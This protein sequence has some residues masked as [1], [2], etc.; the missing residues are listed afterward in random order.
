MARGYNQ[1]AIIEEI[2]RQQ[3]ES[4]NSPYDNVKRLTGNISKT[5]KNMTT[6][7]D[8]MQNN[9]NNPAIQKLGANISQAGTKLTNSANTVNNVISPQNYFKGFAPR[10]FAALNQS[11]AVTGGASGA[12]SGTIGATDAATQGAVGSLAGIP[13]AQ[14]AGGT[15]GSA[16]SSAIGSEVAGTGSA[17]G[18]SAIGNAIGAEIGGTAAGAGTGS[19]VGSAIGAEVGGTAAG[20]TAGGAAGGA[21]AG[22]GSAAAATGIGALVA[23][24][25]MAA[26]GNHRKQAKKSGEALL[27]AMNKEG[28]T[29][30]EQTNEFAK[31][32]Q[33]QDYTQP[34]LTGAAAPINPIQEYQNYL[35]DNGYGDDIINGVPQG[36]NYGNKEIDEWIK[37]YNAGAGASNPI[38]IPQTDEEIAAAKAGKFNAPIQ[39]ARAEET[40]KK[41]LLDKF[42]NGIG[43][44][45][46]G[47]Q[48]NRNNGF[49]PENL[50]RDKTKSK[51]NHI[52]EA[53]G[54]TARIAQNPLVQGLVAGGLSAALTGNPLYGLGQGYKFA[55]NRAMSNIYEKALKDYGVDVQN[56][57]LFGNY[58]SKDFN[59]L[60]APQ[61]KQIMADLAKAK[62]MEQENYHNQMIENQKMLNGIRQQNADTN[63]YKAKNGSKVTHISS[64]S[65]K[66]T[67]PKSTVTKTNSVQNEAKIQMQA[68]NGKVYLVPE[69][70]VSRYKKLGGK[71]VG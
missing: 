39:D 44:L 25:V 69:S 16:I 29:A 24:G 12:G 57:G 28:E 46:S 55:N 45:A 5:G 4:Q 34:V 65:V 36:L 54:T 10:P 64:G 61:Y 50:Q 48:E 20:T 11:G 70:Q 17:L 47:Y 67:Q 37:Q 53:L 23:L 66:T 21:A 6:I 31:K 41:G 62:L 59:A 18:G 33:Q 9:L 43:D 1:S 14:L 35:R 26:M 58:D 2:L 51:M 8:Y 15:T 40:I 7:G 42:L 52:G 27:N 60:M 32:A 71:I 3:Q 68:P 30:L 56:A 63:E 49:A 19:T 22:A 38:N 13:A